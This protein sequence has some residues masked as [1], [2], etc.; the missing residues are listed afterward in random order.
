MATCRVSNCICASPAPT[1]SLLPVECIAH[2]LGWLTEW[3]YAL[4]ALL[5]ARLVS[6]KW[7]QAVV[8]LVQCQMSSNGDLRRKEEG[9]LW[10]PTPGSGQKPHRLALV[11]APFMS[12]E[13]LRSIQGV[14][15]CKLGEEVQDRTI[16][17]LSRGCH[18]IIGLRLFGNA[19][20]T[21]QCLE[22]LSQFSN[23]TSL[24]VSG[25]EDLCRGGLQKIASLPLR[26]L[27]M[28]FCGEVAVGPLSQ[29]RE[30]TELDL[31]GCEVEERFG[32]CLTQFPHLTSIDL[33]KCAGV[34][35]EDLKE[36]ADLPELTFLDVSSCRV[37]DRGAAELSRS[38]QLKSLNL[39]SCVD[40]TDS[41]VLILSR[42]STLT[43]ID[44]TGCAQVTDVSVHELSRLPLLST[45]SLQGCRKVS[46]AGILGLAN[47]QGL[48]SL[49]LSS[50]LPIT[51]RVLKELAALPGLATL[52]VSECSYITDS[53]LAVLAQFPALTDLDLGL[54]DGLTDVGMQLSSRFKALENLHCWGCNGIT[55]AGVRSLVSGLAALKILELSSCWGVSAGLR[56]ETKKRFSSPFD[57]GALGF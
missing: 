14:D 15:L 56:T 3:D 20:L 55:D 6:K 26:S 30:L 9:G 47:A 28:A 44:L 52:K 22:W 1:C 18:H 21:S 39:T 37:G 7:H 38:P 34:T 23:L 4:E 35:D 12:D 46:E 25:C 33:G 31:S 27:K 11:S 8:E 57:Y 36:L 53:S 43:A 51:E 50:R 24:D 2:A 54:C 29:F 42:V 40:I 45:L 10:Q 49:D 5:Q 17:E 32:R 13:F 16:R 48:T 19:E 41:S